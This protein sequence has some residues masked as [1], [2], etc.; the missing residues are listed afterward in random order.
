MKDKRPTVSPPFDVSE[1]M[2]EPFDPDIH[3][4]K[5]RLTTG[6]HAL[7]ESHGVAG[8]VRQSVREYMGEM[9]NDLVAKI[10][11]HIDDLITLTADAMHDP[12]SGLDP[13]EHG[14]QTWAG[15]FEE[16]R[17]DEAAAKRSDAHGFGYDPV[18]NAAAQEAFLKILN[19]R[20]DRCNQKRRAESIM[21]SNDSITTFRLNHP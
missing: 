5:Q 6:L 17:N 4:V 19:G 21:R 3:E 7:L 15:L 14:H 1:H 18:H 11:A 10:E 20:R 13:K 16:I 2:V 12:V 9:V 8:A